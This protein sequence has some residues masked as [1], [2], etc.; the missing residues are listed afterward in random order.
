MISRKKRLVRAERPVSTHTTNAR[1]VFVPLISP[2]QDASCECGNPDSNALTFGEWLSIWY[3]RYKVPLLKPN[4][5][6][7][8]EQMIRLH[9]PEDLKKVKLSNV[10]IL[11]IDSALSRIPISRTYTYARQVWGSAL[12][13]AQRLGL[14]AINPIELTD[15]VKYKRKKSSA[16]TIAEQK[17]FI[18]NLDNKRVKWLMLF[19]LHTGVRRAEALTLRWTD[20]DE[21]RKLILI[22]GTKTE[23]SFRYI[24]LTPDVKNF[25][26]E[27][28]KQNEREK[29]QNGLIF[30]YA[31]EWVSREFKK[32]CP[33]HH[34]H[35]LRH[36]YITRCAECGMN[37]NV[38][39]QLVGHSTADMTLNVYT[40]VMDEFKRK[41]AL[42]FT[43]FPEY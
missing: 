40:H 11:D 42:K 23:D 31:N 35:D 7:N 32:V 24:L 2:L 1:N 15:K 36:T 20:V 37:V 38:C 14:I 41:E 22:K 33:Q 43:I 4:S 25:L 28:R 19:Y 29:Q 39:Q 8:I 30:P 21:D 10:G 12:K 13:K 16:L 27:Q 3:E 17:E 9:T 6:R 18:K 26:E 34:L 5:L